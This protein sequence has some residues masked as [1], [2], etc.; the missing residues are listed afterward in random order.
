MCD[1]GGGGRGRGGGCERPWWT[2][3]CA[4]PGKS[5]TLDICTFKRWMLPAILFPLFFLFPPFFTPSFSIS[6]SSFPPLFP[7][8]SP[9]F[10]LFCE[11]ISPL[12][13]CEW[14]VKRLRAACT[15]A[16]HSW[17]QLMSHNMSISSRWRH[18]WQLVQAELTK[19]HWAS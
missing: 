4:E 3:T 8:F 17:L 9:L 10:P 13:V 19:Q 5:L 2:C 15:Y 7:P 14:G 18:I 1:G 12:L 11:K 6:R 16:L